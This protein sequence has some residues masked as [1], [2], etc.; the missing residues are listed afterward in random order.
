M[1][2]AL[3]TPGTDPLLDLHGDLDRAV[4]AA[5]HLTRKVDPIVQLLDLNRDLAA[6]EAAGGVVRSPG[7]TGGSSRLTK[8]KIVAP[9]LKA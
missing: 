4:S 9:S 6:S 3:R 8:V 1:Y 2:D 5:Y 7:P